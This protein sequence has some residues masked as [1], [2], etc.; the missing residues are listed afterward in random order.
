MQKWHTATEPLG[1]LLLGL[2]ST[3][4][5]ELHM[6]RLATMH[7]SPAKFSSLDE[8]ERNGLSQRTQFKCYMLI[9]KVPLAPE[10][11]DTHPARVT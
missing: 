4:T 2:Q 3:P 1:L 5:N 10:S 11:S 7:Q 8:K 6:C 9:L